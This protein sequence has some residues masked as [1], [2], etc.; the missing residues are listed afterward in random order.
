MESEAQG[1]HLRVLLSVKNKNIYQLRKK[2][3]KNF[4]KYCDEL[5]CKMIFRVNLTYNNFNQNL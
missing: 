3:I 4:E 2:K 1:F 5:N